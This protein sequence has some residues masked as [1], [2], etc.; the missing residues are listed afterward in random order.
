MRILLSLSIILATMAIFLSSSA[1]AQFNDGYRFG[2]GFGLNG[3]CFGHSYTAREQ[4]PFFALYPPVY[5]SGIVKRPYGI[6]PFA[7]PAG[8]A[9]VEL[10]VPHAITIKNPFFENEV[11]PVSNPLETDPAESPNASDKVTW[12]TNPFFG[13]FGF[14]NFACCE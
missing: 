8:I 14:E 7:A 4:P 6:S 3:G 13:N 1:E 11:T 10:S 5:Y 9:P 12:Q 2:A